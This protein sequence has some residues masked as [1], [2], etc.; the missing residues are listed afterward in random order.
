MYSRFFPHFFQ[1]A[2]FF[3]INDMP[4]SP[5]KKAVSI[6]CPN[7]C[8]MFSNEWKINFPILIFWVIDDFVH[9]FQLFLTNQK[10]KKNVMRNLWNGFLSSWVLFVKI[11]VFELWSILYFTFVVHSGLNQFRNLNILREFRSLKAPFLWRISPST[12]SLGGYTS[13][14]RK[15]LD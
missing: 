7:C 15:L 10:W 12:P 13:K 3:H 1:Q 14:T 11:L 6:F 9:N 2:G 8:A 4:L 5:S